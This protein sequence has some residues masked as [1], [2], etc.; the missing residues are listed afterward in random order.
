MQL[1]A[2][3]LQGEQIVLPQVVSLT[4]RREAAAPADELKAVVAVSSALPTLT[5]LT[6]TEN[7]TVCFH[8]IV[9][10]QHTRLTSA[11]IRVELVCRSLEALLLDNEA[12]PQTL[13]SPTQARLSSVLLAPLGLS[14]ASADLAPVSGALTIEKGT[15]CWSVLQSVT[16][17]QLGTSPSVDADGQVHCTAD[18]PI[19]HPL[20]HVTAAVLSQ[21]PCQCISE[22]WQQSTRLQYDTCWQNEA[23][24]VMRRRYLS[25]QQGKNPKTVLSDS[26]KDSTRLTVTCKGAW[27]PKKHDTASVTVPGLGEFTCCPVVA[28]TYRFSAAGEETELQLER[29]PKE[30]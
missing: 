8:G 24:G 19:D 20:T 26:L 7:G 3:A 27:L 30:E 4:L 21:L 16:Q 11:G 14:F 25:L 18:D 17:A 2:L 29:N 9:D 12:K 22:V 1:T 6:A 10:E 15:S 5:R 13:L 23:T 28:V